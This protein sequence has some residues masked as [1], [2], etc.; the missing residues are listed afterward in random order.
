MTNDS[1]AHSAADHEP[2][3]MSTGL[4]RY[5]A[6]T[7]RVSAHHLPW[8]LAQQLHAG[9]QAE[10]PDATLP[11]HGADLRIVELDDFSWRADVTESNIAAT[12]AVGWHTL[13]RLLR[14]AQT[15]QCEALELSGDNLVLP[16]VLAF[17]V[18]TWP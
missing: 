1:S 4:H 7:L 17:E 2:S 10:A 13:G 16:T 15:H 18:F 9:H 6:R 5:I 12:Q 8:D 3:L 14:L 11:S